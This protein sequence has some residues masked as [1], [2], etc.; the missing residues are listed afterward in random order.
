[1]TPR[2]PVNCAPLWA[3][4]VALAVKNPLAHMGSIPES[5]R[6]PGGGHGN[7]LQ[8]FRRR[9]P[10]TEEPGGL[11]SRGSPRIRL[12]H[13]AT[14]ST[15]H[16]P[17][18]PAPSQRQPSGS[19]VCAPGR[20]HCEDCEDPLAPDPG[21]WLPL[22]TLDSHLISNRTP[23]PGHEQTAPAVQHDGDGGGLSGST[24]HPPTKASRKHFPKPRPHSQL[25]RVPLP[26][27]SFGHN[28][29][30]LRPGDAP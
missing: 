16:S 1:M 17:L 29:F 5:G 20:R 21:G 10:W 30:I 23:K 9:I 18:P 3:S 7:P 12:W 24:P 13:A 8:Y 27:S 25:D 28:V 22:S 11:L 2:F 14:K 19:L 4:Q 26:F 15:A 6:S